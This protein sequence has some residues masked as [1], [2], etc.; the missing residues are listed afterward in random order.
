MVNH[1]LTYNAVW[2]CQQ[3]LKCLMPLWGFPPPGDVCGSQQLSD[4]RKSLIYYALFWQIA[5]KYGVK[6]LHWFLATVTG[7]L[8]ISDMGVLDIINENSLSH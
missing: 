3:L 4:T 2:V 7:V 8:K 6:C 5:A 1:H